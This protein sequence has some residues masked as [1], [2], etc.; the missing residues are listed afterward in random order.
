[1]LIVLTAWRL[2]AA[3]RW[4]PALVISS[5]AILVLVVAGFQS[6]WYALAITAL[7][8]AVMALRYARQKRLA[9][10]REARQDAA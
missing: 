8:A 10:R 9:A 2:L 1:V 6:L 4:L 3:R 7:F 5:L